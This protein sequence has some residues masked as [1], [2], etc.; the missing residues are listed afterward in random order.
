MM[1]LEAIEANRA[2]KSRRERER[3]RAL[4]NERVV[5]SD[6][7]SRF[8]SLV[9]QCVCQCAYT[10]NEDDT[11]EKLHH[12]IAHTILTHPYWGN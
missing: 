3:E 8:K 6:R 10:D 2:E 11:V 4:E 7:D 5:E 1:L 9:R 12:L